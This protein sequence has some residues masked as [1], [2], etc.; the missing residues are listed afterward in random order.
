MKIK[1]SDYAKQ[2]GISYKTA[3]V[4][5][6]KGMIP[7]AERLQS[8]SI[9]INL[10]TEDDAASKRTVIYA[11]VSSSKQKHD[12]ERQVS[13]LLDY[14]AARGYRVDHVYKEIASGVNDDRRELNKILA[15]QAIGRIVVENKDRLTRFGFNYIKTLLSADIEVVHNTDSDKEDLINDMVAVIY[16][17]AARIYS[18]RK[19]KNVAE[20]VK[21][22]LG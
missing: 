15:D 13:R 9:R 5:F 11:R 18:R 6:H 2:E 22:G 14:C 8:G 1:L 20:C 12:L 4:W 7:N 10:D 19:A 21:N 17:F 16:S 3:W